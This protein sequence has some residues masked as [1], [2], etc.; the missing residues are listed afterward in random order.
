LFGPNAATLASELDSILGGETALYVRPGLP[1]P[2]I[3]LVTQPTDTATATI[4]LTQVLKTLKQTIGAAKPGGIDLSS[5]QIVH[6][7]AGGQLVISTSQQGLAD[8]QS[9]G[10]KLSSDPS[11]KSAEQAAN[12]PGQTTGFLYANLASALP[13]LQTIGPFL[14]LNVPPTLQTDAGAL[15]TLIAY[16]TRSGDEAGA[17]VFLQVH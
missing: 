12:M 16:G 5:I 13:L 3:T 7:I 6:A 4:A 17:T 15:R 14:G 10:P 11:F 9:A 2:E 1:I 8:F